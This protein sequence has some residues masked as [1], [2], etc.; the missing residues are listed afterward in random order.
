MF[1]YDHGDK[2]AVALE[3]PRV[4][5]SFLVI[6]WFMLDPEKNNFFHTLVKV[7]GALRA[8]KKTLLFVPTLFRG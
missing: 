5:G 1:F 7:E 6:C 3:C 8:R 4:R 2:L